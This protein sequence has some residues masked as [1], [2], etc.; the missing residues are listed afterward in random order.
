[1]ARKPAPPSRKRPEEK[2]DVEPVVA[3]T[4]REEI[5]DIEE[6]SS[7]RT[8]GHLRDRAPSRRGGDGAARPLAMVVGRGRRACRL[9]S[10]LSPKRSCTRISR[11]RPGARWSKVSAIAS[12][13]LWSCWRAS[14][15]S[16]KTRSPPCC[17]CWRRFHAVEPR[18][19]RP[20]LERSCSS[21]ISSARFFAALFSAD[22]PALGAGA[23]R[24][25][26]RGWARG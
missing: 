9:A 8:P 23:A 12:D 11:M 15:S 21:R 18:Q 7:P 16:R 14:S 5:E 3:V 17:P 20:D 10:R 25:H 13:S 1:M 6:R 24:E 22:T 26:A 2:P 19:I 4:E